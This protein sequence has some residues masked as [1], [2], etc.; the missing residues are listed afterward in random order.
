MTF[1][2][3]IDLGNALKDALYHLTAMWDALRTLEVELTPEDGNDIEIETD[4]ISGMASSLSEP[5]DAYKLK[6]KDL[7]EFIPGFLVQTEARNG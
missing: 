4:D 5:S 1:T 6:D 2:L 3:T 7:D